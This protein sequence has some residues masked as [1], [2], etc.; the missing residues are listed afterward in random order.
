MPASMRP[1]KVTAPRDPRRW[2]HPQRGELPAHRALGAPGAG[3]DELHVRGLR[4]VPRPGLPAVLAGSLG[5]VHELVGAEDHLVHRGRR[6][7]E[8]GH[9]DAEG[10]RVRPPGQGLAELDP[11]PVGQRDG[12]GAVHLGEE[13]AELVAA[14]PGHRVE[15][16]H[17]LPERDPHGREHGVPGHVPEP[18]VDQLEVVAV[19][20]EQRERPAVPAAAL[21]LQPGGLDEGAPVGEGGERVGAGRLLLVHEPLLEGVEHHGEEQEDPELLGRVPGQHR[22]RQL[23]PGEAGALDPADRGEQREPDARAQA[24]EEGAEA[25]G[26]EVEERHVHARAGVDVG[27]GHR[28]HDGGGHR[29]GG[30]RS[31]PLGPGFQVTTD[32][33]GGCRH[34]ALRVATRAVCLQFRDCPLH[35]ATP[36]RFRVH[37]ASPKPRNRGQD[38]N[39]LE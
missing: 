23:L 27:G 5:L 19:D 2:L 9:P 10:H 32:P 21:Q 1:S 25:D 13:H 6:T 29:G 31:E 3:G 18:V 11:E 36:C 15:S 37:H 14:Q 20:V 34:P 12:A 24:G 16:A 26:A 7:E 30:C 39:H 33:G 28:D 35:R 8:G 22:R 38:A 17:R 4:R